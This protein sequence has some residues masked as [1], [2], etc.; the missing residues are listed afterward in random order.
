MDSAGDMSPSRRSQLVRVVIIGQKATAM[1]GIEIGDDAVILPRSAV[2]SGSV[3]GAG[4]TWGGV[5]ARH[6]THSEMQRCKE[7]IRG[8]VR[9]QL[10]NAA[11]F[12]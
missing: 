9:A 1:G 2:L 11:E 12:D 10:R 4:Q 6:I 5:P 3:V 7:D 8:V